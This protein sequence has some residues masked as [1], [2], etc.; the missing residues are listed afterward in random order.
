MN[1]EFTYAGFWLRLAATI[2]DIV[3]IYGLLYVVFSIFFGY[4][5]INFGSRVTLV[6]ILFEWIIP[7]FV[8]I[9][10]WVVKSGTPGKLLLKIK[11]VRFDSNE[12][13]SAQKLLLRYAAYFISTI[14]FCL[15]FFCI[16]WDKEKR[17]WHDKISGTAVI[18]DEETS[19]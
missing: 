16:L 15:G 8:V 5:V 7:F 10:F 17:G 9:S 2:I 13:A 3:L 18:H 14:P 11:I 12:P 4:D 1:T 6:Q 19:S